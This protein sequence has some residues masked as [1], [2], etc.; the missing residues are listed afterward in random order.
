MSDAGRAIFNNKASFN[1]AIAI[2]QSTFTGGNTLVD[3]HGSGSGVGANI[4]F[5]NDHNTDKF[6]VGISGDT[7]GDALIYNAENSNMLFGNNNAERMRI[8]ASGNVG[9][10]V[11]PVTDWDTFTTL[12]IQGSSVSGL[13]ANNT[14]LG[15]N[16]YHN[17]NNFKYYGTGAATVYQQRLGEHRWSGAASGSAGNTAS[18][19]QHM[20]VNASGRVGIGIVSPTGSV[21]KILQSF[22]KLIMQKE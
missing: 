20:T 5:A 17:S 11:A 4:A 2:G 8:D 13:G 12:Q 21:Q 6:F 1:N 16:V 22:L 10:G 15:S 14:V 3:I 7:S 18:M 9:I 19:T